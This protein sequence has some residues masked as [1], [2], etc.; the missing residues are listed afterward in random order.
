LA[1]YFILFYFILFSGEQGAGVSREWAGHG[2]I[3]LAFPHSFHVAVQHGVLLRGLL[4]QAC[5]NHWD[6]LVRVVHVHVHAVHHRLDPHSIRHWCLERALL[7][8][9]QGPSLLLL[10]APPPA[11]SPPFA[12]ATISSGV[13][14][15]E[16][17][18]IQCAVFCF[19]LY[20]LIRIGRN[21]VGE[22]RKC[23]G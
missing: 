3:G 17:Q 5:P 21:R 2:G 4:L 18:K 1:F 20:I 6:N 12:A 15:T 22:G 11:P 23:N 13:F 10:V 14:V 16:I 9:P 7:Q 8:G 19:S